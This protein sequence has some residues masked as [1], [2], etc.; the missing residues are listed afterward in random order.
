MDNKDFDRQ[1]RGRKSAG[2]VWILVIAA[3]LCILFVWLIPA[4]D[5]GDDR[6]LEDEQAEVVTEAITPSQAVDE[7]QIG[8]E[9]QMESDAY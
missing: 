7:A 2:W 4:R 9:S 5:K 8:Q 3:F 1:P 6:A